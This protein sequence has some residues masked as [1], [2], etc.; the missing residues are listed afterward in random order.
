MVEDTEQPIYTDT[1]V[2][3][4]G[5]LMPRVIG[6][7]GDGGPP[8]A[9][10]DEGTGE[11]GN[12]DAPATPGFYDL[13]EVPPH[14]KSYVEAELKKIEGNVTPKFQEHAE[15]R[16]QWEPF[17]ET[18]VA[19]L[20][21]DEVRELVEFRRMI[22]NEDAFREWHGQIG[23]QFGWSA[24]AEPDGE[25][26]E[27]DDDSFEFGTPD[28]DPPAWAKGLMEKV[29][30]L[31]KVIGQSQQER[32]VSETRDA[33]ARQLAELH[34][35]HGEFDDEMVAKLALS[36]DTPDAIQKGFQDY[37]KLTA[38]I[39]QG[40]VERKLNQPETP[41]LGGATP[42][43]GDAPTTFDQAARAAVNRL[44]VTSGT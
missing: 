43:N 25:P 17:A 22:Q 19:D 40:L 38:Q 20:S 35:K 1:H 12:G 18:G 24:T 27:D 10:A 5:R 15:F 14:L 23:E 11:G 39:E 16:K 42:Q 3:Y 26:G 30:E 13:S 4:G 9:V 28:D 32:Q 44:K 36:Y 41:E 34:E 2:L 33:I 29:S 31:D 21:P 37:T 7:E 8:A 6:A